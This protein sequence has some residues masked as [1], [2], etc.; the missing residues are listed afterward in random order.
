DG[1]DILKNHKQQGRQV[2]DNGLG[3]IAQVAG[4]LGVTVVCADRHSSWFL[5]YTQN[6]F[7]YSRE[8]PT[9]DSGFS[10]KSC[11]FLK[12]R[13]LGESWKGQPR[14]RRCWICLLYPLCGGL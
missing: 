7:Y 3:D 13:S 6:S 10:A 1:K 5:L 12:T 11:N 9:G 8:P 2:V 4:V 14:K